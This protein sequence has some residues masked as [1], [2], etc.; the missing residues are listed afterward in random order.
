MLGIFSV[1]FASLK[2]TLS[3]FI[4]KVRLAGWWPKTCSISMVG[5]ATGS[6]FLERVGPGN[7]VIQIGGCI[8][9]LNI[10]HANFIHLSTIYHEK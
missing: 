9:K 6:I 5:R 8:C 7:F 4:C 10:E 2:P 3:V 1:N